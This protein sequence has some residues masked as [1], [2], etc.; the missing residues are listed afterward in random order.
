MEKNLKYY[1]IE[2][3]S[4]KTL[5]EEYRELLFPKD[6]QLEELEDQNLITDIELYEDNNPV[7]TICV[8]E[9]EDEVETS[10]GLSQL[11]S[12]YFVCKLPSENI[13]ILFNISWDDNL[14]EYE[15]N[16]LYAIGGC[17]THKEAGNYL[18]NKFAEDNLL[19]ASEGSWA[20]FLRSLIS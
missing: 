5:Y 11:K 14:G 1:F 18:L 13:F 4:T 2:D 3:R 15:R 20:D 17:K 9:F 8:S 12:N 6:M 19:H 7:D 16:I 10:Y